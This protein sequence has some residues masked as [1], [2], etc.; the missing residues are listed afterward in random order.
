MKPGSPALPHRQGFIAAT[1][2][3]SD[4]VIGTGNDAFARFQRLAQRIQHLRRKFRELIEE[5]NAVVGK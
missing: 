2:W 3:I 1:S 4:A 5:K